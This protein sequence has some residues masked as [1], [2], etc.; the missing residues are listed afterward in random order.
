MCRILDAPGAENI[1]AEPDVCWLTRGGMNPAAFIRKYAARIRQ[2]HFKDI[3]VPDDPGTTSSLGRGVVDLKSSYD[4]VKETDCEW[5]IYE[6]DNSQDPFRS[7][8]ESLAFLK[9]L[10]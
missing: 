1:F 2:V 6:Q 7:A 10:N 8:E 3:A 9:Q 4:A 5:I